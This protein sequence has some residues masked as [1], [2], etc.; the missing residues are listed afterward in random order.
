MN[1][2][3]K[4]KYEKKLTYKMVDIKNI[5]FVLVDKYSK[6][7]VFPDLSKSISMNVEKTTATIMAYLID[8]KKE[9]FINDYG[10]LNNLPRA[11]ACILLFF[12]SMKINKDTAD[13][14]NIGV[15]I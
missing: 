9:R 15:A 1:I 10:F 12:K 7:N 4:H 3:T 13:A 11:F 8:E 14:I 5:K 6:E 2:Y